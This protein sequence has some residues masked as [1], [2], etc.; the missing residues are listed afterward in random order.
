M[1][2][3][4]RR[5][6]GDHAPGEAPARGPE[7]PSGPGPGGPFWR[8]RRWWRA[9]VSAGF[10]PMFWIFLA[11]AALC[12]ALVYV[13]E[14]EAAFR[15]ALVED[16]RMVVETV[17]RVVVAIAVAGMIWVLMPRE[18]I[19][20]LV[21]RSSGMAGLVLATIA[22]AITPGGPTSAFSLL[23]MLGALGADRG[24][25]IAYIASWAT[26]GMQR[27]LIWDVPMMGPDFSLLRI[28]STLVLPVAAGLLARALPIRLDLKGEQ[29]LRD[30]L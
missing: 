14:G 2:E 1:D 11:I 6:G 7:D 8:D 3:P 18:R 12:G 27:I 21:G 26:L 20:A 5:T 13:L 16:G 15:A 23:A 9:W 30:R 4:A 10:G 28:A 22:G 25:M 29:R 24:T 17:P 19:S